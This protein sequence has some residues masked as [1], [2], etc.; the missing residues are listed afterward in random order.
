MLINWTRIN[1]ELLSMTVTLLDSYMHVYFL[2][3]VFKSFSQISYY[4]WI[5]SQG[6]TD[7]SSL[8]TIRFCIT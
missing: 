5:S 6:Q 7:S 8:D 2:C 1:E 4:V 3:D